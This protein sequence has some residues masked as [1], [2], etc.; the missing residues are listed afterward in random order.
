[1]AY[2][3][4]PRDATANCVSPSSSLSAEWLP[5]SPSFLCH[6]GQECTCLHAYTRVRTQATVWACGEEKGWGNQSEKDLKDPRKKC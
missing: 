6:S 2:G 3:G 4:H 1:M 5:R